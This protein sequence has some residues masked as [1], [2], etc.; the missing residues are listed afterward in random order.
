VTVLAEHKRPAAEIITI[1]GTA[2]T[3]TVITTP[4]ELRYTHRRQR[5]AT[6]EMGGEFA[7]RI[8]ATGTLRIG[9]YCGTLK[10]D[11]TGVH[12]MEANILNERR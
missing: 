9:T 4:T 11:I 1:I 10:C 5:R 7:Y 3:I 2:I 6:G 12:L 8:Y